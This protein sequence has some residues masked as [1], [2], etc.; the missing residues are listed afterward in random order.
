MLV[1]CEGES[2]LQKDERK[3]SFVPVYV[4]PRLVKEGQLIPE[5]PSEQVSLPRL[6]DIEQSHAKLSVK[7][8]VESRILLSHAHFGE[9]RRISTKRSRQRVIILLSFSYLFVS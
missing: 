9:I 1:S 7:F 8:Q 2:M 6:R 4:R 5:H 3:A